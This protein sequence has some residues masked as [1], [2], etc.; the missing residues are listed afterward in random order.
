MG[1]GATPSS[2][3]AP[4]AWSDE[5][6]SGPEGVGATDVFAVAAH[7]LKRLAKEQLPVLSQVA[8]PRSE[9]RLC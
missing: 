2:D 3:D 1:H 9:G 4:Q 7:L 5:M 6:L 8:W